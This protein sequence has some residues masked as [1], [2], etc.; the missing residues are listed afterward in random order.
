MHDLQRELSAASNKP[1]TSRFHRRLLAVSR[2][3]RQA[4]C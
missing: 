1:T 3:V 2:E 4:D